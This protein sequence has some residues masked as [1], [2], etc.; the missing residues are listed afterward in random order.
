MRRSNSSPF[1]PLT[2]NLSR[3][4]QEGS[5][6]KLRQEVKRLCKPNAALS[7]DNISVELSKE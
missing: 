6:G 5:L 4:L 3:R 7:K 2:V 1:I